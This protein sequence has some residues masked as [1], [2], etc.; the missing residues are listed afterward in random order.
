MKVYKTYLAR[1]KSFAIAE[2]GHSQQILT[3]LLRHLRK[4][5]TSYG[6][7]SFAG[8]FCLQSNRKTNLC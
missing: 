7:D 2:Q 4:L 8:L 3:Q 5:Y 6:L 1:H